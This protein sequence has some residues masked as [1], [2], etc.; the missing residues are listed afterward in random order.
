MTGNIWY[1]PS[2]TYG[3]SQNWLTTPFVE[4]F[5]DE[6]VP[7]GTFFAYLT[8]QGLG[9]FDRASQFGQSLYGKSRTGYQAAQR[10]NPG[11]TYRAYLDQFLGPNAIQD[12]YLG[13]TPEQR[14][15]GGAAR[16]YAGRA[17]FIGRG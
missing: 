2:S 7:Q 16:Q 9:G 15:E 11:L 3:S 4:Q 12:Q 1:D 14:G 17:R 10:N 8:G 6:Q 5:V 13:A